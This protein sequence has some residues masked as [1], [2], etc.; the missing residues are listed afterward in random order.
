MLEVRRPVPED[1]VHYAAHF[2]SAAVGA[3]LWPGD[4]GGPRT[5]AEAAAI[6]ASDIAHWV[7]EGFGPWACFAADGS[8]AGHGGLRRTHVEGEPAVEVLYSVFP[9]AWGRGHATD[10]ALQAVAFARE[11]GLAE[12]VG[13]AWTGN[14]ASIRVL[15]KAGLVFEREFEHAGLPHWLGRRALPG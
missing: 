14:P 13:F 12:V 11:L 6:V 3:A 8:F 9:A 15:E 7:E 1:A 5:P 10:I 4:L 2:G